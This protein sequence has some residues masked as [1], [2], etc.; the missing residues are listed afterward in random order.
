MPFA[1]TGSR[2]MP[3]AFQASLLKP[4]TEIVSI[5]D[6]YTGYIE[7]VPK[8]GCLTPNEQ[9][10]WARWAKDLEGEET[11]IELQLELLA[12]LFSLRLK[13]DV[14]V[15]D[16]RDG[17]TNS[18]LI[19]KAWEFFVAE[20]LQGEPSKQLLRATGEEA[21]K[22]CDAHAKLNQAILVSRADYKAENTFFVVKGRENVADDFEI[23]KDY[24]DEMIPDTDV[25]G[26]RDRSKKSSGSGIQPT[27][28]LTTTTQG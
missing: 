20:R 2:C 24:S 3:L 16:L 28:E 9:I 26:K 18:R 17:I 25:R 19:D 10:V 27:L 13:E 23:I 12:Q 8:Y 11:L 22:I 5:G 7:G 21:E 6:E 1:P 14:T 4:Q 15:D